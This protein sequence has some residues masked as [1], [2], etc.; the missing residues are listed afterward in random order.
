MNL[1]VIIVPLRLVAYSLCCIAFLTPDLVDAGAYELKGDVLQPSTD[2]II[3]KPEAQITFDMQGNENGR[4]SF[5][6]WTPQMGEKSWHTAYF[7]FNYENE[8]DYNL[9]MIKGNRE[10]VVLDKRDGGSDTLMSIRNIPSLNNRI[11]M[12]WTNTS[13]GTL[14]TLD[15]IR[16]FRMPREWTKG[17]FIIRNGGV[18]EVVIRH[19]K[20]TELPDSVPFSVADYIGEN[21]IIQKGQPFIFKGK[22]A[23]D[24]EIELSFLQHHLKGR[25]NANGEWKIAMPPIMHYVHSAPLTL[26][27]GGRVLN[28]QNV[29]VGEIWYCSGQSNMRFSVEESTL[30]DEFAQTAQNNAIRLF[31][32]PWQPSGVPRREMQGARWRVASPESVRRFSAVAFLFAETLQKT[33]NVPV[34]IVQ[35]SIGG[36]RI[37]AWMSESLH[38]EL[39][40]EPLVDKT[41]EAPDEFTRHDSSALHNGMVVPALNI[42]VAGTV[43]Y[44]G[45]SNAKD[46]NDYRDWL[47]AMIMEHR[48]LRSAPQMPFYIIQLPGYEGNWLKNNHPWWGNL[49]GAQAE[50]AEE[51]EFTFIVVTTDQG[52]RNNIHPANKTVL[53]KR[54]SSSVLEHHYGM[55][56][57][58]GTPPHF[59]HAHRLHSAGFELEFSEPLYT[60]A[61]IHGFEWFRVD[62]DKNPE[63]LDAEQISPTKI[64][65]Y[66]NS[67]I[68]HGSLR[69]NWQ[70]YPLGRLADASGNPLL[71]FKWSLPLDA[72]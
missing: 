33:L 61:G 10:L 68:N 17:R 16:S 14:L 40:I 26:T 23:P 37:Q 12:E 27:A 44:Q 2:V 1:S 4:I 42:P 20:V 63:P 59:V 53:T 25:V 19:L 69:Y 55:S 35:A 5:E 36:T 52:L 3:L 18:N 31:M 43:W 29:A 65:V 48:T 41:N 47:R 32:V 56:E 67:Q 57:F 46:G 51:D 6:V 71:P 7:L 50:V 38:E 39:S 66:G 8:V 54:L 45:E 9:F 24:S 49:R 64:R 58:D 28:Y 22:G 15:Q 11:W 34:G 60:N 62:N 21:M 72:P 13:E 70:N 30:G